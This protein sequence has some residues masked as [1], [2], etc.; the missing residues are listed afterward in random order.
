MGRGPAGSRSCTRSESDAPS[1][2]IFQ[3]RLLRKVNSDWWACWSR[4]SWCN[5]WF[6]LLENGSS[7]TIHWRSL[8]ACC[9]FSWFRRTWRSSASLRCRFR[10]IFQHDPLYVSTDHS[11]TFWTLLIAPSVQLLLKTT[12]S[13]TWVIDLFFL[14]AFSQPKIE[15]HWIKNKVFGNSRLIW[16]TFKLHCLFM[17]T[18]VDWRYWEF[19][20]IQFFKKFWEDFQLF[21]FFFVESAFKISLN[22]IEDNRD[23]KRISREVIEIIEFFIIRS[24]LEAAIKWTR[25]LTR[26]IRFK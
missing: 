16:V 15:I 1:S 5:W 20:L 23:T 11:Q 25:H 6:Q 3:C 4:C 24:S 7:S 17:R 10:R 26:S 22:L 2:S 13:S 14:K 9:R 8:S 12:R 19:F 21:W 18:K